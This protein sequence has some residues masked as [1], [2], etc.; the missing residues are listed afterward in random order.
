MGSVTG[1]GLGSGKGVVSGTGAGGVVGSLLGVGIGIGIG[2]EVVGVCS[3]GVVAAGALS[4]G[5][6]DEG[7]SFVGLPPGNALSTVRAIGCGASPT[8]SGDSGTAA[9]FSPRGGRL[10]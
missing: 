10:A 7:G 4:A 5:R 8:R 1:S 3:A 2:T 9:S 6:E